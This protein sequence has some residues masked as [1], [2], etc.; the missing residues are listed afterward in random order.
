MLDFLQAHLRI[1]E[2]CQ[3]QL[4]LCCPEAALRIPILP[5]REDRARGHML[6][7]SVHE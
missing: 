1:V 4:R 6:E 3:Q 7:A 2:Y 5:V